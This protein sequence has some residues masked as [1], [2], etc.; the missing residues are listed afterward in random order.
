MELSV[1]DRLILLSVLPQEGNIMEWK[2]IKTI[3][4]SLG[5]SEEEHKILKFQT[6]GDS[7]K[8]ELGVPDKEVTFGEK[9]TD[10]IVNAFKELN[11]R[12]KL[13]EEHIPLYEKFVKEES[14]AGHS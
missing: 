13:R 10:I 14:Y 12:K 6:E 3:K 2:I 8:W 4:E 7:V 5:F 11:K 9:A 1:G